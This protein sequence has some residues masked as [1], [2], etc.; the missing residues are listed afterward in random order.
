MN[1]HVS[2][3][4]RICADQNEWRLTT[5][6][7]HTST[8]LNLAK[9]EHAARPHDRCSPGLHHFAWRVETQDDVDG[10]HDLLKDIGAEILDAPADY[11]P[12]ASGKGYY[13]VSFADADRL[14]LED[15]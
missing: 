3:G 13:A 12:Y 2:P 7:G 5:P 15:A 14:R 8:S 4:S 6:Q 10:F 11:P 1:K 9:G